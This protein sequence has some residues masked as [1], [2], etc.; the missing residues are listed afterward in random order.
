MQ[1]KLFVLFFLVTTTLSAQFYQTQTVYGRIV[2]KETKQ[3]ISGALVFVD[4]VYPIVSAL[5]DIDGVFYLNRVPV[6]RQNLKV[7]KKEYKN[8]FTNKFYF[9]TVRIEADE[10]A[11]MKANKM[12]ASPMF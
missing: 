7:K 11:K 5:T 10:Y 6:G 8:F 9:N 2:D 1:M 3:P 12:T 4:N